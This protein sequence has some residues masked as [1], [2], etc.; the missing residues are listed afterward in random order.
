MQVQVGG[1]VGWGGEQ[2]DKMLLGGKWQKCSWGRWGEMG[3]VVVG[4]GGKSRKKKWN[5]R[6]GT[7]GGWVCDSELVCGRGWA[8]SKL[9]IEPA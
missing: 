9:G 3:G 1:W 2:H 7:G 8:S 4:W 6:V 5:G